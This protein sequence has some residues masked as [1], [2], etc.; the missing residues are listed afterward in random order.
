M[1]HVIEQAGGLAIGRD[2]CR[3]LDVVPTKLHDRSPIFL[4]SKEDVEDYLKCVEEAND[5][6]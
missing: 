5:K 1:A 4:G 3:M 2:H 6:N